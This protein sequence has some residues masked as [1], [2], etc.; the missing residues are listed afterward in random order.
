[1]EYDTLRASHLNKLRE[2][3]RFSC[4]GNRKIFISLRREKKIQ[5]TQ[6]SLFSVGGYFN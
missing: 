4:A 2:R 6:A 3:G 1:V 5:A